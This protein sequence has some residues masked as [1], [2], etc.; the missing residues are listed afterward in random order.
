MILEY[1]TQT[2]AKASEI[3]ARGGVIAFRTD[4]FYGLGADP[5]NVSAVQKIKQLKGREEQKPILI[6]ISDR[7]QV[8][9]FIHEPTTTF[10]L[11]AKKFWP[12]P[13]T[14]VGKARTDVPV[15]VTAGTQTVGVRLPADDKV[16]E[17]I[18][19]CGGALTATSA[20]PSNQEPAKTA[21][22]VS[23]YFGPGVD[24]TVDD[25]EA[26]TDQPSTV[27]NV[28][29]EPKLIREGVV[30]WTEIQAE[31]EVLR[32]DQSSSPFGRG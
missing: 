7:D 1:S 8:R 3:I 16:R 24:L 5:F 18:D 4:T 2:I 26:R 25:G 9:R 12:G 22:Q 30:A 32:F 20:N 31:V 14:L 29:D 19:A 15:E 27:V 21:E 23:A 6:V 13:L 28:C 17:L 10:N 11:L